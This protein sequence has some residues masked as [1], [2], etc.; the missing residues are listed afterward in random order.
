MVRIR[1]REDE[2]EGEIGR[3]DVEKCGLH[4]EL[5]GGKAKKNTQI[6]VVCYCREA[7]KSKP[8]VTRNKDHVSGV[9][10]LGVW[11]RGRGN[12]GHDLMSER[13]TVRSR[14]NKQ[15][16]IGCGGGNVKYLRALQ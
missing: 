9:E 5:Y 16:T 13:Y 15:R 1:R 8:W 2:V 11:E 14:K 7:T 10:S 3:K 4:M 12:A 6:I